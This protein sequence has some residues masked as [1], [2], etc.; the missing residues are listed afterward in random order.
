VTWVGWVLVGLAAGYLALALYGKLRTLKE[1]YREALAEEARA[2]EARAE[3]AGT[4]EAR[5]PGRAPPP[6]PI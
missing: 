4:E 3:E 1:R 6:P 2:E 5:P